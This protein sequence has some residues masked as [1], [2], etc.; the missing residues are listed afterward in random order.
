[1]TIGQAATDELV[2]AS[3]SKAPAVTST[4][5]STRLA[6]VASRDPAE[7]PA[8]VP[9]VVLRDLSALA[10]SQMRVVSPIGSPAN[11]HRQAASATYGCDAEPLYDAGPFRGLWP[12][13]RITTPLS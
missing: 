7:R 1:M 9:F 11:P 13:N 3:R 4:V 5:T 12:T 6:E 8:D 2:E 10:T